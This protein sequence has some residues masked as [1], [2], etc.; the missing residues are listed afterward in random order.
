MRHCI[1]FFATLLL[2]ASCGKGGVSTSSTSSDSTSQSPSSNE[3]FVQPKI[4]G[5]PHSDEYVIARV[6]AI[7]ENIFKENFREM[8][9]DDEGDLPQDIPS[10]DE[11]FCTKD[12]NDLLEKVI[13]YD[14]TNKPDEMGF[15]EFDY[16]V[17]GQDF[18]KL[19]ISDVRVLKRD[20]D[21]AEVELVLH[22]MGSSTRV[23]LELDFERG[24]WYIDD[25]IDL[26]NDYDLREEME[27]YIED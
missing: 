14:N 18:D 9:D 24:E 17:M 25:I 3:T 15:F 2:L 6:E 8:T 26:D 22:N 21:D 11:K 19:S 20:K 13:E 1:M 12:W 4:D 27:A 10:P 16:W 23:R 5:D 7:Y